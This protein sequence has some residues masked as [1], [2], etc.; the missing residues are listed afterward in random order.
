M[1]TATVIHNPL[2]KILQYPGSGF[3]NCKFTVANMNISHSAFYTPE[4]LILNFYGTFSAV[5]H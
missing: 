2:S 1:D 4:K 5:L 3:N